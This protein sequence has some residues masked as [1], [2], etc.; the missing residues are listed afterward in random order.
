[1]QV[2]SLYLRSN[3]K[4]SG[5]TALDERSGMLLPSILVVSFEVKAA[6]CSMT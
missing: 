4:D 1:M 2:I 5:G 6:D 3:I